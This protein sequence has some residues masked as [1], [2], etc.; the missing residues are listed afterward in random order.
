MS[1]DVAIV[2][3][4]IAGLYAAYRLAHESNKRVVLLERD[5]VLGGR[6]KTV[7]FK[8]ARV[9]TGAGIAR[10]H[11]DVRLLRLMHQL[12]VPLPPVYRV[13]HNRK[14]LGFPCAVKQTFQTVKTAYE[15]VASMPSLPAL[16]FKAFALQVLGG[17][18]YSQFLQC[19]GY[20]DFENDDVAHVL[21][22]YGFEDNYENW[23][24][25]AVSW[26]ALVQALAAAI[27]S[28]GGTIFQK[29]EVK[30]IVQVSAKTPQYALSTVSGV[31]HWA[32]AIIIATDIDGIRALL[33]ALPLYKGI[34]GQPFLRLYVQFSTQS[35]AAMSLRV[36]D[37]VTLVG[38][39]LQ[40]II[41]IKK[42]A[43]IY[44]VA[45]CDNGNAVYMSRLM[46][47]T[48]ANR[49]AVA[50][51]VHAALQIEYTQPLQITSMRAFYFKNGTHYYKPL[52]D[53][54][55]SRPEFLR[56]AQ[57]PLPGVFVVG[58]VV[59]LHQGW[60]EGALESVDA[61]LN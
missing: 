34:R 54:L 4:G 49:R 28:R 29:C 16:T 42:D 19:A 11:K 44:M 56:A 36:L 24:A 35:A 40:K 27:K 6:A 33:P 60:V 13:K 26:S 37:G 38:G 22:N 46:K 1:Y 10:K 45:Y 59:S 30:S 31:V 51:L 23:D 57:M 17:R 39:P 53:P 8:G 43:G 50:H 47:N 9:V 41:P 3:G 52:M 15:A 58:E 61:I 14:L 48:S 18:A 7:P 25:V 55:K 21:Y 2:G 5:S 20:T 12:G 32:T